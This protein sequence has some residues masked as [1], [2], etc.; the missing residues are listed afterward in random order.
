MFGEVYCCFRDDFWIEK[1]WNETIGDD[2]EVMFEEYVKVFLKV[3][4]WIEF[5]DLLC[6]IVVGV[7]YLYVVIMFGDFGCFYCRYFVGYFGVDFIWDG[8]VGGYRILNIVKGD[9]WDDM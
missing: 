6:E 3:S 2:W 7:C 1:I 8:K 4:M 9:I 5:G